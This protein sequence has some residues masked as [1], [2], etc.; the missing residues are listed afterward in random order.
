[1]WCIYIHNWV[2]HGM[3]W[4]IVVEVSENQY[5][6]FVSVLFGTASIQ[7]D[8]TNR[9]RSKT[10]EDRKWKLKTTL[11]FYYDHKFV[12]I[13]TRCATTQND[14]WFSKFYAHLRS[15]AWKRRKKDNSILWAAKWRAKWHIKFKIKQK[16]VYYYT[17]VVQTYMKICKYIKKKF[18]SHVK[19]ILRYVIHNMIDWVSACIYLSDL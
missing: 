2:A 1:M 12:K 13:I 7:K 9:I 6:S 10:L 5:Y 15:L 17:V 4:R 18:N 19:S 11:R 14:E 3:N 16:L 8:W